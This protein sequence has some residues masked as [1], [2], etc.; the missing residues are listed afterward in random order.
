M[1]R[2]ADCATS[3]YFQWKNPLLILV[4]QAGILGYSALDGRVDNPLHAIGRRPYGFFDIL[5]V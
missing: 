2:H 1:L 4:D 3:L 5:Q